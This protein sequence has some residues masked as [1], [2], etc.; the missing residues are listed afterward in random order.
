MR[1]CLQTEPQNEITV[2]SSSRR[3]FLAEV[4]LP[5]NY[6]INTHEWMMKAQGNDS[7]STSEFFFVKT[8][9]HRSG[10]KMKVFFLKGM[11]DNTS[12]KGGSPLNNCME[13]RGER[14]DL[15]ANEKG[16]FF[17]FV[18]VMDPHHGNVGIK[19]FKGPSKVT[20]KEIIGIDVNT[21]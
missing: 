1:F 21:M 9:V 4:A 10:S 15:I 12:N 6:A 14:S 13:V 17:G 8:Q 16:T 18:S 5:Y 3:L 7:T 20:L 19:Y 2:L 11:D